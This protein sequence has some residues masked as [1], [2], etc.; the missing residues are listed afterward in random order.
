M[1]KISSPRGCGSCRQP[2]V[3]AS[4][5]VCC[6][7]HAK[8]LFTAEPERKKEKR[9][10]KEK[11]GAFCR[12][13]YPGQWCKGEG[14]TPGRRVNNNNPGEKRQT[15]DFKLR[16]RYPLFPLALSLSCTQTGERGG[17]GAEQWR[18]KEWGWLREEE[19]EPLLPKTI[20]WQAAEPVRG[21][22]SPF[23]TPSASRQLI[24]RVSQSAGWLVGGE[25]KCIR[26]GEGGAKAWDWNF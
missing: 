12:A 19:K 17:A 2:L 24:E 5:L 10:R 1:F 25:M 13:K 21:R 16:L 23:L 8:M 14:K 15:G 7:T 4:S 3:S 20:K 26:R 9:G 22:P 6:L 11:R 18:G